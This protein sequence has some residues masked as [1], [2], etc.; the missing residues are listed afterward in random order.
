MTTAR[1]SL[2]P[3]PAATGASRGFEYRNAS[4]Y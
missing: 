1:F 4:A 3:E 2:L